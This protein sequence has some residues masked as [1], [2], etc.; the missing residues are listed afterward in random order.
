MITK[1]WDSGD[2]SGFCPI[3]MTAG[4]VA[5]SERLAEGFSC[6]RMAEGFSCRRIDSFKHK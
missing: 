3:L 4:Q 6:R 1:T 5:K 2:I